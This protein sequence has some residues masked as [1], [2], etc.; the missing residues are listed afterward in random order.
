MKRAA[1]K[2][3]PEQQDTLAVVSGSM[4][5]IPITFAA[6]MFWSTFGPFAFVPDWVLP[7]TPKK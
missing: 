5:M 3:E 7:R 6:E 4:P 1:P 2:V